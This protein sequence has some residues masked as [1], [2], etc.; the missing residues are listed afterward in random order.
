M[1]CPDDVVHGQSLAK[2]LGK[3]AASDVE[4]LIRI[5]R[6]KN[7]ATGNLSFSHPHGLQ[8]FDNHVY[9][10]N[11]L[12]VLALSHEEGPDQKSELAELMLDM[13][14]T[15]LFFGATTNTTEYFDQVAT[16]VRTLTGYDSVMVYRF[17]A[18]W[19]GEIFCQSRADTYPSFPGIQ[20]LVDNIEKTY[21]WLGITPSQ[22]DSISKTMYASV[23][24]ILNLLE[25]SGDKYDEGFKRILSALRPDDLG[26]EIHLF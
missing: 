25:T 19:N 4:Q 20:E 26:G 15:Q 13:Q 1:L 16:L 8:A 17:D 7:T 6:D 21:A 18:D 9:Q 10:S 5:A 3:V 12:F 22:E 11:G 23:E 2:L 24:K 14:Q